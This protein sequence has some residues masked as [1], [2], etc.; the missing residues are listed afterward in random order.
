VPNISQPQLLS[1]ICSALTAQSSESIASA[2]NAAP[3]AY[4]LIGRALPVDPLVANIR[5]SG[6]MKSSPVGMR[7]RMEGS[8]SEKLVSVSG[9]SDITLRTFQLEKPKSEAGQLEMVNQAL[10][11]SLYPLSDLQINKIEG[12]AL[13]FRNGK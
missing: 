10:L 7:I 8:D 5:I 6:W 12:R 2:Y 1:A 3:S 11:A 9:S 4:L 13:S